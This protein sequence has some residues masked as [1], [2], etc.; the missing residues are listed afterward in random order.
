VVGV[1]MLN[2]PD[3]SILEDVMPQWLSK[4]VLK[5]LGIL[6]QPV[7]TL[8]MSILTAPPVFNPLF[9][10]IRRPAVIRFWAKQAYVS[11]HIVDDDLV[12]ILSHPAHQPRA[13]RALV[14][15]TRSQKEFPTAKT[16]LP[17]LS[18]PILLIWGQQDRLVPPFLGP[19]FTQFN[20]KLQ[21]VELANAGHCPH[22]ECPEEVNRIILDWIKTW[23]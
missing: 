4:G 1:V 8:L 18:I 23:C 16:I 5:P 9:R 15:M 14:A 12:E 21:L 19:L 13:A 22:D 17:Q 2:L 11:A 20:P 6:V 3:R 7:R 10:L